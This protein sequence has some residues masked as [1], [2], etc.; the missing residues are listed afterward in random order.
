MNDYR[1][2]IVCIAITIILNME[3]LFIFDDYLILLGIRWSIRYF[4]II[5]NSLFEI[6]Y[7]RSLLLYWLRN[8]ITNLDLIVIW[9]IQIQHNLIFFFAR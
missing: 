4:Y 8:I 9:S 2:L 3:F 7:K 1:N 6:D 5:L